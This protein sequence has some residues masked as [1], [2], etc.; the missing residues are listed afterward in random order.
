MSTL[1][2]Q[3]APLLCTRG[4]QTCWRGRFGCQVLFQELL[5]EAALF[6][7][8]F[9]FGFSALPWQQPESRCSGC[10]QQEILYGLL[11]RG[12]YLH[13]I[14]TLIRAGN[15][16][17]MVFYNEETQVWDLDRSFGARA[18]ASGGGGG[19][20][21]RKSEASGWEVEIL[22]SYLADGLVAV[23]QPWMGWISGS[24]PELKESGRVSCFTTQ[25]LF[26]SPLP[27][28]AASDSV[29][30]CSVC[31]HHCWFRVM[32]PVNPVNEAQMLFS[33]TFI[34]PKVHIWHGFSFSQK[35][36]F[37]WVKQN[38]VLFELITLKDLFNQWD[39]LFWGVTWERCGVWSLICILH[40]VPLL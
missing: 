17:V 35:H 5:S 40:M 2:C 24:R 34:F 23:I 38:E 3:L 16:T 25:T 6:Q 30:L 28:A 4:A 1:V 22:C 31:P 33:Y 8:A 39:D 26:Q 7:L 10:T 12:S 37:A 13:L 32:I 29:S 19:G 9:C 15:W 36:I 27:W 20:D 11:G 14:F 21:G 18:G